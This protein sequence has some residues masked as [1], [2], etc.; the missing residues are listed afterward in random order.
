MIAKLEGT[1]STALQNKDQTQAMGAIVKN[2]SSTTEPP[3]QQLKPLGSKYQ[4][5]SL[6]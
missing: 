4:I 1:Q 5:R 3:P 6:P 2:V